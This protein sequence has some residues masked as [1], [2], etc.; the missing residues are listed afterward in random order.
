MNNTLALRR[1]ILLLGMAFSGPLLAQTF[2]YIS[3][4][5][6]G[7]I[8]RYALN[9]RT[10]ALKP[11]GETPAGGKVM[12]MA[13]SPDKQILYAAV[14]SRPM[15]LVSWSINGKT[16]A[17]PPQAIPISAWTGKGAF[18]WRLPTIAVW[19]MF[20]ASGQAGR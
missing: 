8:A 20:I 15:R 1:S 2:V 14:R 7:K 3:A 9:D 12:P 10:G 19:C 17:R 5:E 18:C 16:G 6:D 13:I 4:A 11:L